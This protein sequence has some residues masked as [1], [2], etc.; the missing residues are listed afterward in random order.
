MFLGFRFRFCLFRVGVWRFCLLS[1]FVF[2]D[3][4]FDCVYIG[5]CLSV[6]FGF[7][8]VIW[9][10]W[11]VVLLFVCLVFFGYFAIVE[12]WLGGV[13]VL[14]DG[15]CCFSLLFIFL[16]VSFWLFALQFTC[17]LGLVTIGLVRL[18]G[19]CLLL[20]IYYFVVY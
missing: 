12:F 7:V 6:G 11:L 3:L 13:V 16:L 19:W 9:V 17:A 8:F 2:R 5:V 1:G 15:C 18:N 20:F 14:L 10:W 4:A